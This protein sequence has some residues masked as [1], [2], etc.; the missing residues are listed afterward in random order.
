MN[1]HITIPKEILPDYC[2][3]HHIRWLAIFGSVLRDDFG[4]DSD[5]DVLVEFQEGKEPGFLNLARME[6]E[7]T[8]EFGRQ[9]DLRT[10]QDLSHLFRDEVI[11]SA[12]VQYAQ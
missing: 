8:R 12:E 7:L 3:R 2:R 6:R 10:P 9:V 4:P 5:I 11:K 1:R